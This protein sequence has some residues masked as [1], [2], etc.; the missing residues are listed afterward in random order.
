[1]DVAKLFTVKIEISRMMG[2]TTAFVVWIIALIFK[3]IYPFPLLK[4]LL[5][6]RSLSYEL[7]S[8]YFDRVKGNENCQSLLIDNLKKSQNVKHRYSGSTESLSFS[9]SFLCILMI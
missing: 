3:T 9:L 5:A 1:V 4:Y 8:P 7:L 6:S 2:M